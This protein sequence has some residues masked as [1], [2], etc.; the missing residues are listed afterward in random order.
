[1]TE[2]QKRVIMGSL[3][4]G[5]N[6]IGDVDVASLPASVIAG[7]GSL[8]AGANNIGDVDVASLPAT[9]AGTNRIG[10][11]NITDDTTT[12]GVDA[13]TTG[14]KTLEQG[15]PVVHAMGLDGSTWRGLKV[16]A[17]GNV[18]VLIA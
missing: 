11:V 12:A 15:T 5:A 16:D 1:M 9:P 7:M 4:A 2:Y 6:N 3:P 14:L 17:S 10:K 18:Q 13:S 8:P